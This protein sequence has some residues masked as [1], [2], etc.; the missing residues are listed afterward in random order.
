MATYTGT[1]NG[2][3]TWSV[4]LPAQA[5][6]TYNVT[7][8]ATEGAQ[9]ATDTSV[10]TINQQADTTAPVVTIDA[11][12][13]TDATPAV[14]GTVGDATATL[15]VTVNGID[16]TG[17]NNGDGTW[18]VTL[19]SLPVGSY[20]MTVT[21]TDAASNAGT[22]TATLTINQAA[23]TTPPIVTIDP[24]TTADATP[25]ISGSINDAGADL[26]LNVNST[27][28]PAT[29]NQDGT[30]TVT[31]PTIP[32]GTHTMTITATDPANNVGTDSATL[33]IQADTTAPVV[34]IN[35][36]T[37]ADITPAITGTVDDTT[38]AISVNID[39]ADYPATNNA[40]GTWILADNTVAALTAGSSYNATVTATDD[41]NNSATASATISITDAS[42]L[43]AIHLDGA[44]TMSA[45]SV[46]TL[47]DNTGQWAVF[48]WVR[49]ADTT[50]P[51]GS[52]FGSL[53]TP[54]SFGT[55]RY[56]STNLFYSYLY[57]T[58][59]N[60]ND[61]V[62][63]AAGTN[64]MLW[65][66]S[67]D[68]TDPTKVNVFMCLEGAGAETDVKST[69]LS[70]TGTLEVEEWFIGESSHGNPL[71][72]DVRDMCI[73][74][75]RNIDKAD[76]V[77]LSNGA[78]PSTL[79]SPY[80]WWKLNG[81]DD[82]QDYGTANIPMVAHGTPTDATGPDFQ[83][84]YTGGTTGLSVTIADFKTK[85][86]TPVFNGKVNDVDATIVLNV[87]GA[88]Y[89]ATNN[90]DTTWT[91]PGNTI[92]ELAAATYTVT[93]TATALDG[94]I[95]ID[96]AQLIKE[97]SAPMPTGPVGANQVR[98]AGVLDDDTQ[99]NL[100]L[101]KG[102]R[103]PLIA[104]SQRGSAKYYADGLCVTLENYYAAPIGDVSGRFYIQTDTKVLFDDHI[105][106]WPRGGARPFWITQ[107][108]PKV[109]PDMTLF[110][111]YGTEG[112]GT[113]SVYS[114][115]QAAPNG[116]MGHGLITSFP[117]VGH[118][119]MLGPMPGWD[120]CS[121]VNPTAQNHEVARGMADAMAVIPHHAV[122]FATQD[123][124]DVTQYPGSTMLKPADGGVFN[125]IGWPTE[126]YSIIAGGGFSM[127]QSMA[128]SGTF[129]AWA[130]ELFGTDF[131]KEQLAQWT[132]YI[133]SLWE[134]DS[135]RLPSGVCGMNPQTRG[136]ARGLRC[137]LYAAKYSDNKPY[138]AAWVNDVATALESY[139]Q[140]QTGIQLLKNDV[141]NLNGQGLA[142]YQ[143]K[144]VADALGLALHMG[145]TQFQFS[146]DYIMETIY[147]SLLDY[148]REF[149]NLYVIPVQ[150]ADNSDIP[151][152]GS[153]L[154]YYASMDS[155]I[156]YGPSQGFIEAVTNNYASGSP[157][158]VAAMGSTFPGSIGGGST[159][160]TN[161]AAHMKP[162]LAYAVRYGTNTARAQAAMAA[163]EAGTNIDFSDMPKYNVI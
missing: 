78:A 157:E 31:L 107:P 156:L 159:Q 89:T 142:Y 120:A 77:S 154:T 71:V 54:H 123:M 105:T 151:D 146:F 152:W 7:V 70:F 81:E 75:D 32:V 20:T 116:P 79:G 158:M 62:S 52:P 22:D 53:P 84:G 63:L 76:M 72:G 5:V 42:G 60:R 102:E 111:P 82:N 44:T 136:V 132:N 90:G 15:V 18:D 155:G 145:Y 104:G 35:A 131:D 12:T 135:Y 115:Y 114:N 87:D 26:V 106:I 16:T 58:P 83:P 65:A 161:Y 128:H 21:A 61:S 67:R 33:T 39:N 48:A 6:G 59:E 3:G 130:C 148:P 29:N 96:T 138:F 47:P 66:L 129:S 149:A 49:Y 125:P 117:A 1:N 134:N 91:L 28:T 17:T 37:T 143:Q 103:K 119:M 74:L 68:T 64:W 141:H 40:N 41:N 36:Q 73:F 95:A 137:L 110:P 4:T 23:D 46:F 150:Y 98:V 100:L 118:H 133:E 86:P 126:P 56:A 30:W 13:T 160:D 101:E 27:N 92:T 57:H 139:L 97:A 24:V 99:I 38:A 94:S 127:N 147:A 9:T 163:W 34:T 43:K 80:H 8:T 112:V 93:V 69:Q 108:T 162:C 153:M 19:P 140:A 88:D 14:S 2:D 11:L 25:T 121:M 50:T 51:N 85:D 109:S 122:D 45:P 10:L 55:R 144:F 124:L 113:A